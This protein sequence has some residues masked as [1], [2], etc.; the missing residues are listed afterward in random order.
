MAGLPTG[1][2]A[3]LVARLAMILT[4]G[5]AAT[6]LAAQESRLRGFVDITASA[7]SE[8]GVP[9]S[10]GVGQYDLYLTAKLSDRLSF[11]GESV[12]EYDDMFL[13]DVERV[14][15]SFAATSRHRIS[16]GKFHTPLGFW[17]T[18]YHHGAL[19]QPTISRPQLFRFEDEGGLLPIHA[20]GVQVSG[21]DLSRWHLGY[22]L[23]VANGIGATPA[24]DNDNAKAVALSLHSQVTSAFRVGASAYLDRIAAGTEGMNGA[25]LP[26][27]VDARLMGAFAVYEGDAVEFSGEFLHVA[28][29]P[30][31]SAARSG[32]DAWYL[33]AGYRLGHF[34]P[35]LRIDEMRLPPADPYFA[36]ADFRQGLVGLRRDLSEAA[37]AKAELSRRRSGTGPV[38]TQLQVQIA[39]GF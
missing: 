33:Y 3:G 36:T 35:Y 34:V 37:V 10:F 6:M 2:V 9:S 23:M 8:R 38:V 30:R 31:T 32:T 24:G 27:D 28:H 39:V 14:I 26:E 4:L 29:R 11:L 18:A 1:L 22:D 25:P 13:V 12:F 19:L 17:N 16:A 20:T 7:T 15:V 21:R 5:P